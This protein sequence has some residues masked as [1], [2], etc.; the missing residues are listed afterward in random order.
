MS[1]QRI[2]IGKSP[3]IEPSLDHALGLVQ[4]YTRKLRV[5]SKRIHAIRDEY[6]KTLESRAREDSKGSNG[7]ANS[8]VVRQQAW[9][10]IVG[11]FQS[12]NSACAAYLRALVPPAK[13]LALHVS[14]LATHGTNET[15]VKLELGL[16]VAEL[17]SAIQAAQELFNSRLAFIAL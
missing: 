4:E 16:R 14:Q 15:I 8:K 6:L 13:K 17:E 7:A 12:R 1:K 10:E 2:T 3:S 11:S 9:F 5:F